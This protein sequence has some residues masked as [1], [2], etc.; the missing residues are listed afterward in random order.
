MPEAEPFALA[1]RPSA[2]KGSVVNE[3]V[4]LLQRW[5]DAYGREEREAMLDSLAENAVWHVGGTHRFSGDYRGRE[6]ILGYFD[7][8]RQETSDT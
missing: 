5:L 3:Q 7:A 2:V 6:A 8:V 1:R 4:E